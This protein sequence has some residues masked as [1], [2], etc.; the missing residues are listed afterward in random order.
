M[1]HTYDSHLNRGSMPS[2]AVANKLELAPTLWELV[3]L[4][5]LE[6][7]TADC[8]NPT[9]CRNSIVQRTAKSST[10]CCCVCSVRGKRNSKL[11]PK[12]RQRSRA[13]AVKIKM[14]HWVQRASALLHRGHE[15]CASRTSKT[16]RDAFEIQRHIYRWKWYIQQS[17]MINQVMQRRHNSTI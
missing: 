8:Q 1:C 11:S 4:N 2:M 14:T 6:R 13:V 5:V 9:V 7:Q 17:Q 16:Q 3:E 10:Q 15:K 12:T